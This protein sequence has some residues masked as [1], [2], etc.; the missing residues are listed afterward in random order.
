MMGG[1]MRTPVTH[2]MSLQDAP[3]RAMAEG[4]KTVELRL[5]DE[6]RQTVRP[7]DTIVFTAPAGETVT[8]RVEEVRRFDSFADLYDALDP[9]ELGYGPGETADPRDMEAY[10]SPEQQAKYG[11]VGIRVRLV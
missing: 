3:F 5:W 1:E 11:V 9:A 6:K 2:A 4:R 7:G 10:Y 8:V